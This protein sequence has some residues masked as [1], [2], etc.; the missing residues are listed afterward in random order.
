MNKKFGF[1]LAEVMITVAVIGVVAA[2]T[3]P[4]LIQNWQKETQAL[5]IR[6][7]AQDFETA[8]DLIT[9]NAMKKNFYSTSV[10][11]SDNGVASLMS[12]FKNAKQIDNLFSSSYKK[13][14][15]G[16]GNFTCSGTQYLLANSAAICISRDSNL[17]S[18]SNFFKIYVDTNG[19]DKPN[20]SGRDLFLLYLDGNGNIRGDV[21]KID[22][23]D[24]G[25]LQEC[26]H[27]GNNCK[28]YE[29]FDYNGD[30]NI[31][32]ADVTY[33]TNA[34]LEGVSDVTLAMCKNHSTG[35]YCFEILRNNNWVM[36]Y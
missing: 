18:V 21:P 33:L 17:A 34:A 2:L 30:G 3:L 31:D 35:Q 10:F 4:G 15:G 19:K 9:T 23:V 24:I 7:V 11:T 5:Q 29:K 13:I 6:K 8:A 16:S 28:D 12:Y 22:S 27:A 26:V 14:S 36:N 1:T 25:A 32:V 20:I